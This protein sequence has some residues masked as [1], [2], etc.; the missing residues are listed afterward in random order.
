MLSQAAGQGHA[1]HL[2]HCAAPACAFPYK[3][4]LSPT[5]LGAFPFNWVGT[6]AS[7]LCWWPQDGLVLCSF[8]E[9]SHQHPKHAPCSQALLPAQPMARRA[10]LPWPPRYSSVRQ[11]ALPRLEFIHAAR[12]G[13][14]W[15]YEGRDIALFSTQL[16]PRL[17]SGGGAN[18]PGRPLPEHLSEGISLTGISARDLRRS[19]GRLRQP[20]C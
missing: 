8:L 16:L 12:T 1:P 3:W 14:G 10:P 2:L 5:K 9:Q 18:L 15:V 13:R 17:C 4:A 11:R 6:R 7:K 20:L 19:P